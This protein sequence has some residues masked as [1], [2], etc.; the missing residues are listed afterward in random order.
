MII[1]IDPDTKQHGCAM[2][3]LRKDHPVC[4][5]TWTIQRAGKKGTLHPNYREELLDLKKHIKGYSA[6][7]V[8]EDVYLGLNPQ[9]FKKLIE[10][11]CEITV[12]LWI[13]CLPHTPVLPST[14]MSAIGISTRA[15][16]DAVEAAYRIH[17]KRFAQN[18]GIYAPDSP[19]E[20]AARGI[21]WWALTTHAGGTK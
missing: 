21:L 2:G 14:W 20:C 15:G 13:E 4:L 6:V 12:P 5:R 1:A 19:H 18:S 11:R 9:T 10:A 3:E 16:R 17:A 8:F 7:V